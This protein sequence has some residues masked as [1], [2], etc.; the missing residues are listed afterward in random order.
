M[1]RSTRG[2]TNRL[3]APTQSA[4]VPVLPL[5]ARWDGSAPPP[6]Q[7]SRTWCSSAWCADDGSPGNWPARAPASPKHPR[8]ASATRPGIAGTPFVSDRADAFVAE[9][10]RATHGALSSL[11]RS[12]PKR[13]EPK[14]VPATGALSRQH[15]TAVPPMEGI[16]HVTRP[17]HFCRGQQ[18]T[19]MLLT[20]FGWCCM[21]CQSIVRSVFPGSLSAMLVSKRTPGCYIV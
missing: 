16:T 13:L 10:D 21:N 17:K 3:L 20:S 8:P 14:P 2:S 18:N 5:P 11:Q 15:S 1:Q 4:S 7:C 9:D 12:R 6:A 19:A